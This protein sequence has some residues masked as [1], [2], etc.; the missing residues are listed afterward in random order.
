M[1]RRRRHASLRW[2]C[3]SVVRSPLVGRGYLC[4]FVFDGN[5]AEGIVLALGVPVPVV[6]H[7]YASQRRVPVEDDAEEVVGFPLVPVGGRI[8]P[9]QRGDVRIIVGRRHFQ[10]DAAI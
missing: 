6:G 10:A 5:S 7:L 3:S 1:S 8:N 4:A 9:E 2:W